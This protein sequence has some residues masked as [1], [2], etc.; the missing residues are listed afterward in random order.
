MSTYTVKSGD[1]LT[2]I[3][4]TLYGDANRW[5]EIASL[6]K[7]PSTLIRTGQ[8]LMVPDDVISEVE[9]TSTY[10]PGYTP[11]A[12]VASAPQIESL[13]SPEIMQE[14]AVTGRRID[15]TV[16]AVLLLGAWALFGG[17]GRR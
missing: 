2:G 5:R 16:L 9:I 17:A 7:L 15:Y 6:N 8:K 10:T 1:T 14:V 3:A 13:T 12:P 11:G 4:R